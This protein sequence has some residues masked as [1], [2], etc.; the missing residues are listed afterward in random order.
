MTTLS[1][2]DTPAALID[3]SKMQAN[4]ARMQQQMHSLGVR[5]RPHVKTSKCLP[6]VQAQI[7][8]GLHLTRHAQ[9]TAGHQGHIPL[10]RHA[11]PLC[12]TAQ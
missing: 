7:A 1:T 10:T 9:T 4:I 11:A 6:V 8:A 3:R 2:L 12:H 5:F